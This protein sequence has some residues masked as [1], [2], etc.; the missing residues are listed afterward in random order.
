[1]ILNERLALRYKNRDTWK[2]SRLSFLSMNNVIVER[3]DREQ[4]GN[5]KSCI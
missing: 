1:M 2:R 4:V 5:L 3:Y